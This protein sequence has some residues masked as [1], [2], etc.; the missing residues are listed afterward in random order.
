MIL[1]SL[2]NLYDNL[3]K[4]DSG[5]DIAAYGFTDAKVSWCVVVSDAGDLVALENVQQQDNSPKPKMRAR[6]ERVPDCGVRTSGISA[7]VLCDS[8]AYVFGY[9]PDGKKKDDDREKTLRRAGECFEASRAKHLSLEKEIHHPAFSA[10]C[11]FYEKWT[12]TSA[13]V[14]PVLAAKW[15]EIA[16]T[17]GAFVFR[18]D[19]DDQPVNRIPAFR[20]AW[21]KTKTGQASPDEVTGQCLVTGDTGVLERVHSSIKGVLGA[22]SSGAAVVSFNASAFTSYGGKSLNTINA[23][24]GKLAAFKYT[25]ALNWLLNPAHK[26]CVTIGDASTVFWCDGKNDVFIPFFS[27]VLGARYESQDENLRTRLKAAMKYMGG[28]K[29]GLPPDLGDAKAKFYVLGLAPNAARLSVRFWYVSTLGET[30]EH[31]KDHFEALCIERQFGDDSNHPEPEFPA[32][33][34]LLK[35][36]ARET[37]DIPP[38]LE[39]EVLRA[40]LTGEKYPESLL[41]AILR[42]IAADRTLNYYRA[43]ALK[44][45]LTRNHSNNLTTPITMSLD[46]SCKDPAYLL[47]RLFAALEKAQSDS[48]PEIKATIKDRFFSSASATPSMIFPRLIQLDQHHLRKLK[49]EKPGMAVNDEKLIGSIMEAIG[50]FPSRLGLQQQ[51]LFAIGYYHQRNDFF[52]K[53]DK[54]EAPVPEEAVPVNS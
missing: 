17:T 50:A 2:V 36:T 52:K 3:S 54:P 19:G 48:A 20:D 16:K 24:V 4:P 45:I 42:R 32:P 14:N 44:A 46:T 15:P 37:K 6:T 25:T 7:N 39:G 10:V 28:T 51:G 22:Q 5:E 47:G 41:T 30:Y 53:K 9:I 29:G 27:N 43:A 26:Q 13:D 49:G 23:P 38:V 18:R 1:Q 33:W 35:E 11:R 34:Q 40:I 8:S 31:L 12:P 21:L